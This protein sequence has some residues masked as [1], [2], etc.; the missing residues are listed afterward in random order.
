M[1]LRVL[2]FTSAERLI[3]MPAVIKEV[4]RVDLDPVS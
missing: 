1:T 3:I 4:F 2:F